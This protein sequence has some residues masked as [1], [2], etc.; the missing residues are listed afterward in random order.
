MKTNPNAYRVIVRPL[1]AT[2]LLLMIPLIAMQL[3]DEV[4]WTLSDFIF[5]GVLI[6]GVG[7]PFE[8]A[9]RKSRDTVYRAGIG[10]ALVSAFLL[11]WSNAAV[12]ITDSGADAFYLVVVAIGVVGAFV[13]RFRPAGM[14]RAMFVTAL[15]QA[16]VG[17]IALIAGVVPAFNSAFQ[18][19]GITGFFAVLFVGSA[20]LFR[21]A[22]RG[23]HGRGA[24]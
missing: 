23:G 15:A 4:V 22:A 3:T 11:L 6:L 7:I 19:L 2:A 5:A 18:I 8:L 17:V 16:L 13:A 12:G 20:L 1:L 9:M 24:A 21:L 14:A 10:L